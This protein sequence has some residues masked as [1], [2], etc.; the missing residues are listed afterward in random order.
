MGPSFGGSEGG[1]ALRLTVGGA[2]L[3]DGRL[4][5]DG[6]AGLQDDSGGGSGGS[7]WVTANQLTGDGIISARGGEGELYGG[8]G[9]GGGRI[10]LYSKF[11]S[12]AG[13]VT[14]SGGHGASP[15][16]HGTVYHSS[17]WDAPAIHSHTPAGVI[18]TGVS[19][20]DLFFNA[21]INPSSVAPSDVVIETPAGILPASSLTISNITLTRLRISFPQQ[22]GSGDY[23]IRA[24]PQIR[25]FFQQPMSQVY[26]GLFTIALPVIQGGVADADGQPVAG[27]LIQPSGGMSAVTTDEN[28]YYTLEVVSGWSGSITPSLE[29]FTFVP[30]SRSYT[31]VTASLDNGNFL[32]VESIAPT[33]TSQLHDNGSGV[34]NLLRWN[35]IP[36][37]T[38]QV[39]YSTNLVDWFPF[40][41]PVS[42]GD[43]ELQ[44]DLPMDDGPVK[45]FRVQARN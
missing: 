43:V 39:Q 25:D 40:G 7:I 13:T 42:G 38:Y 10:A 35:A 9:G 28:G 15:G 41:E 31:N 1:G 45:F 12:F 36:G 34:M 22:I 29:A 32:A 19:S 44:F 30:A 33:L 16:A 11:N 17:H 23:T 3:V 24:G 4:S 5:A 18:S 6:N 27:V 8:G 2:L 14:A 37:V 21:L 20:V 26:T